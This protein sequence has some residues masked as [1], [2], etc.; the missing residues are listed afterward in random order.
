VKHIPVFLME[1]TNIMDS[2]TEWRQESDGGTLVECLDQFLADIFFNAV[3][4]TDIIL[5]LITLLFSV[6]VFIHPHVECEFPVE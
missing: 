4:F 2:I 1:F 6:T 3:S 5:E